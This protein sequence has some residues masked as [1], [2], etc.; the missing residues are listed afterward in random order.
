MTWFK[1][2]ALKSD[3]G[4]VARELKVDALLTGSFLREGDD[5]RIGCQ[6]V[7]ANAESILWQGTFDFKYDK[8]LTVQDHVATQTIRGLE[9]T[10]S[11]SEFG[12]LRSDVSSV[13]PLAYEFYL[14]GVDLYANSEFP[15]RF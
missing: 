8:L 5:I 3:F 12:R 6:L 10:L 15:S 2:T 7:D 4:G 13:S 1:F 14:S 11:P 9:L